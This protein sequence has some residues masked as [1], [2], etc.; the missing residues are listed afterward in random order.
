MYIL[1]LDNFSGHEINMIKIPDVIITIF[2][3]NTVTNKHQTADMGMIASLKVGY[4]LDT[5]EK[6][7][8]IIN[9]KG[10]TKTLQNKEGAAF[11]LDV[12]DWHMAQQHIY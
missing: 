11:A 3:Y 2:F 7:L 12:Q 9:A 6:L 4:W 8:D 5:L 1:L 10:G